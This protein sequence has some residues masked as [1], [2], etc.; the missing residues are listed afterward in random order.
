M[1]PQTTTCSQRGLGV[2]HH[3]LFWFLYFVWYF[4]FCYYF[5]QFL[6]ILYGVRLP[7]FGVQPAR[8][9]FASRQRL[10]VSQRVM[11]AMAVVP[12]TARLLELPLL[13]WRR[14]TFDADVAI[15]QMRFCIFLVVCVAF[16]FYLL[17]PN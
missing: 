16:G 9:H 3:N 17:C 2:K 8:N 1:F 10:R 14:F 13:A 15:F 12:K 5:C 6:F 4:L 11:M 7:V